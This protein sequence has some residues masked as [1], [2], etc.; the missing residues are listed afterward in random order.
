MTGKRTIFQY[1][2]S[3]DDEKM[4][5]HA[6]RAKD[7]TFAEAIIVAPFARAVEDIEEYIREMCE[8]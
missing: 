8:E 1:T 6:R 3:A 4:Q 5:F 2:I 7:I